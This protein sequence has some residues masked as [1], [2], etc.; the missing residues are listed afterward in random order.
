M[1]L[2]HPLTQAPPQLPAQHLLAQLERLASCDR[3]AEYACITARHQ[4]GARSVD[5]TQPTLAILL[6]GRKQVHGATRSLE[7][8]PGDVFLMAR[9]CR[10]DVVNLPDPASGI[11]LSLTIPL[12]DGAIQTARMAW[13]DPIRRDGDDIAKFDNLDLSEEL[14]RW[15]SAL[16][17]GQL[18]EA[19]IA[20]AAVVIA[21]CRRGQTSLLAPHSPSLAMQVRDTVAAQPDREWTS[22][23]FETMLGMSGATLRRHL[24]AEH[25]TLR[26]VIASARLGCALTLLYTTRW[27]IKTVAAK[28]GYRSVSSFT[29]RFSDRYGMGPSEIGNAETA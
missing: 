1:N 20:L 14:Q 13:V 11:Y 9:R 5:V 25:T 24:V 29:K 15:A 17:A 21:L 4:H 23:D 2:A 7:F 16:Q 27:P 3:T 8:A 10:L 19:R 12:C 28:V 18:A 26:D 22:R 6:Q